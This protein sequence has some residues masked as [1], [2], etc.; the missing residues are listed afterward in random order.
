MANWDPLVFCEDWPPAKLW[1]GCLQWRQN[2]DISSDLL[3]LYWVVNFLGQSEASTLDSTGIR[4]F[5]WDL[6]PK[7]LPG[8][9]QKLLLSASRSSC[10]GLLCPSYTFGSRAADHVQWI[11]LLD[12]VLNCILNLFNLTS[13]IIWQ[14]WELLRYVTTSAPGCICAKASLEANRFQVALK[15]WRAASLGSPNLG[16]REV[17]A[18]AWAHPTLSLSLC[19]SVFHSLS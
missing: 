15:M 10:F 2:I 9:S 8:D 14:G 3:N 4:W 17:S 5:N 1:L 7:L 19:R 18:T 16:Q 11:S 13:D 12:F 6:L